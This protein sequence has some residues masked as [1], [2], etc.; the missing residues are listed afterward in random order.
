MSKRAKLSHD[1]AGLPFASLH[2]DNGEAEFKRGK[3]LYDQASFTKALEHFEQ[4]AKKENVHAYIY[5]FC[6]YQFGQGVAINSKQAEHWSNAMKKYIPLVRHFSTSD[7]TYRIILAHCLDFGIGVEKDA[8]EAVGLYQKAGAEGSADACF[9]LGCCLENGAPPD[10]K[11][12]MVQFHKSAELGNLFAQQYLGKCYSFGMGGVDKNKDTAVSY[13]KKA[14]AGGHLEA[15]VYLGH[16][17]LNGEGVV[18]DEKTGIAL[19][20]QAAEQGCALGQCN[21]AK[22][23]ELG[24]EIKQDLPTAT[25]WYKRGADQ[26]DARCQHE[27]AYCLEKGIGITANPPEAM[28][29]YKRA[30]DQGFAASQ[31]NLAN[32]L[33]KRGGEENLKAAAEYLI[34]AADQGYA[35]AQ[36]R[37]GDFYHRGYGVAKSFSRAIYW[38]AKAAQKNNADAQKSLGFRIADLT[39]QGL[40]AS[41]NALIQGNPQTQSAVDLVM[42][43]FVLAGNPVTLFGGG[44]TSSLLSTLSVDLSP[45]SK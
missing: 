18:K 32:C 12:A 33:A 6:M 2:L 35:P 8:K 22:R 15:H 34:K 37:L 45:G 14:V 16:C 40:A 7:N 23:L 44:D 9:N 20:K 13:F 19:I 28:K 38:Y 27:Y 41:L 26:G 1:V 24:K 31:T 17:F 4:A 5:L 21:M 11:A 10:A 42:N 43:E 29:W 3:S 36:D 39:S 30:A 25:G